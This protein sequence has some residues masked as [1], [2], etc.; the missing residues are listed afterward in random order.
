MERSRNRQERAL[1]Q[2]VGASAPPQAQDTASVI[3]V[4]GPRSGLDRLPDVLSLYCPGCHCC[5][6]LFRRSPRKKWSGQPPGSSPSPGPL[7]SPRASKKKTA[8]CLTM[9]HVFGMKRDWKEKPNRMLNEHRTG[10]CRVLTHARLLSGVG[11][12]LLTHA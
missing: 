2:R 10:P 11:G 1:E 3:R 8:S 6:L 12:E 7:G 9:A 5:R 4:P